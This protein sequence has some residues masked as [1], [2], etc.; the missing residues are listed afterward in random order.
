MNVLLNTRYPGGICPTCRVQTDVGPDIL[1]GSGIAVFRFQYEDTV[2]Y[3]GRD[4][5]GGLESE[6]LVAQAALRK[7]E[8]QS[9]GWFSKKA[10]NKCMFLN[11]RHLNCQQYLPLQMCGVKAVRGVHGYCNFKYYPDH[12]NAKFSGFPAGF[13]DGRILNKFFSE[14]GGVEIWFSDKEMRQEFAKMPA[15]KLLADRFRSLN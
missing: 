9:S 4:T 14:K 6:V 10:L 11:T 3:C 13:A 7:I 8:R 5:F 12:Q 15:L 1:S 2:Q